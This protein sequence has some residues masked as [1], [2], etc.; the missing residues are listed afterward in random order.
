MYNAD[1]ICHGKTT[2]DAAQGKYEPTKASN[3]RSEKGEKKMK[4]GFVILVAVAAV[5]VMAGGAWAGSTG[6][7]VNAS[8]TVT[9]VCVAG[10][11]AT[12]N[13]GSGDAS[14]GFPAPVIV[15]P[16]LW[17]TKGHSVVSVTTDG[18]LNGGTPTTGPWF[19][20]SA[21]TGDTV[22]YTF[23]WVV[24]AGAGSGT[25]NLMTLSAPA[26]TAAAVA[27]AGAANDYQDTVVMTINY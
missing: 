24:A 23:S 21:T 4:K 3:G 8:A 2:R 19:L 15:N 10:G 12:I 5:L 11:P 14:A 13:F 16:T 22:S 26:L 7:T 17:C 27:S 18:G 9:A 20:K 6:T 25:T 1:A